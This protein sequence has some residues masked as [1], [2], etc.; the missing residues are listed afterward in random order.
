MPEK[1]GGCTFRCCTALHTSC[2]EFAV[3]DPF[4]GSHF[5]GK[6][7]SVLSAVRLR[8]KNLKRF[9]LTFREGVLINALNRVKMLS[10]RG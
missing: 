9:S 10:F 2:R 7:F 4:R 3:D 5:A 6:T 8:V 1:P